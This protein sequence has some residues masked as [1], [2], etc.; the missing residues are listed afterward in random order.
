MSE[1]ERQFAET[2]DLIRA[3]PMI[4]ELPHPTAGMR[5]SHRVK[6]YGKRFEPDGL[7]GRRCGKI[8]ARTAV[9]QRMAARRYNVIDNQN[10]RF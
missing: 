3:A 2:L 9:A 1:P 4:F 7:N 6:E 10:S 8:A 5:F